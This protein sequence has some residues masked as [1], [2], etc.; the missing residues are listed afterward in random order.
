MEHKKIYREYYG[1][2][3]VCVSI[4]YLLKGRKKQPK[5]HTI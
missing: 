2:S 3:D 4:S 1:T 5:K